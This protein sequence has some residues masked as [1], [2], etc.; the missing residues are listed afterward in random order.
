MNC[1]CC[2]NNFCAP[3]LCSENI[4]GS[5]L[6]EQNGKLGEIYRENPSYSTKMFLDASHQYSKM[7]SYKINIQKSSVLW[8][9]NK[10]S[11]GEIKV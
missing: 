5:V 2:L 9:E 7:I 4:P 10:N 6:R 11:E 8:N 3:T 1:C